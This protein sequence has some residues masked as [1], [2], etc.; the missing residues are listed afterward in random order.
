MKATYREALNQALQWGWVTENVALRASPP[1]LRRFEFAPPS[2]EAALRLIQAADAYDGYQGRED[3]DTHLARCSVYAAAAKLL[4]KVGEF[5][6]AL[7]AP[8]REP[9]GVRL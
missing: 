6:A 8:L 4:T 2:P 1:R 5:I 9:S 7:K 3:R